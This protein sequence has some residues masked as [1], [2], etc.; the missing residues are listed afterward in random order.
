MSP[1]RLLDSLFM[2][3]TLLTNCYERRS[4]YV[5]LSSVPVVGVDVSADFS[6]VAILAPDGSGLLLILYLFLG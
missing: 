5:T 6:M 2:M 1:T 4:Y 3:V